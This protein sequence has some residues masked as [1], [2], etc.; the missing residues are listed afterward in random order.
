[1]LEK[2]CPLLRALFWSRMWVKLEVKW[3]FELQ[4]LNGP[5]STFFNFITFF[6]FYLFVCLYSLYLFHYVYFRWLIKIISCDVW[7]G[8]F[9]WKTM[10]ALCRRTMGWIAKDT[11]EQPLI[12]KCNSKCTGIFV[13]A[14]FSSHVFYFNFF[15]HECSTLMIFDVFGEY[16]SLFLVINLWSEETY[17]CLNANAINYTY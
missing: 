15:I 6:Q 4:L 1:M 16:F 8:S 2:C 14:Y 5:L 13:R 7:S 10:S 9:E 3:K 17:L 11:K 12:W